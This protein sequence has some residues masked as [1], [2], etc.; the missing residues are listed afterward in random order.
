MTIRHS[1]Q[2]VPQGEGLSVAVIGAGAVGLSSAIWLQ[3]FG[4][5]VTVFD[6]HLPD[7]AEGYRRSSSFGNACTIALGAVI[8]V[9]SPGVL[10]SVPGMLLDRKGPLSVYWR[11]LFQLFP[12]L[13]AFIRSS[14]PS[15]VSRITAVLGMLMREAESGHQPL[16]E[17]VGA[18][19]LIRRRGCLYLYEDEAGFAAADRD[20]RLRE[21]EGVKMSFLNP[22]QIREREPSLAP[23][24]HKGLLFEDAYCLDS[25]HRYMVRL[26]EAVRRRGGDLC[27]FDVQKIML[28]DDKVELIGAGE[29][30]GFD[31]VVIAGG[32]WSG[33]LASSVGDKIRLNTERGYHVLFQESGHLLSAPTCYPAH[34]FYM[35]PQTE[36]LRSAGTVELG[37]LDRP[38]REVRTRIIAE[39]T[40]RFLPDIGEA[41]RDWLG[42]RP[43]MPDS[44][45]VIGTSPRD[46]RVVYAFGHGHIG[47]TLGGITGRIVSELISGLPPSVDI[48]ALR[49]DRF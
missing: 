25:P 45:P 10:K 8:P 9:A 31:R 39:K 16:L 43:S 36:G 3:R 29:P 17:E 11:D 20:I 2:T 30:R 21:R 26:G 49:S 7:D 41:G 12:W 37:G 13:I 44:L 1:L 23:L 40:R 42:F 15:E 32:A 48:S 5:K 28:H 14:T 6:R 27:S 22:K 24:Y 35:S 46:R 18:N 19:D 33:R 47:L 38:S 34:G 4:H